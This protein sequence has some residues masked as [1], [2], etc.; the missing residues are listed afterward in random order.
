MGFGGVGRE[1]QRCLGRDPSPQ[2]ALRGWIKIEEIEQIVGAG[3]VTIGKNETGI[4]RGRVIK[5]SNRLQERDLGI[6]RVGVA[7]D[8]FLRLQIKVVGREVFGRAFLDERFLLRGNRR[9]QLRH[10]GLRDFAL[11]CEDIRQVAVVSLRPNLPIRSRIDQVR[12]D[13]QA[14]FG[15]L[16]RSLEQIGDAELLADFLPVTG[17]VVLVLPD[18]GAP[19]DF[20]VGDFRQVG[21][22]LVL[23]AV[24]E[25]RIILFR[26][27][28]FERQNRDA[29]FRNLVVRQA[30]IAPRMPEP[31][32]ADGEHGYRR[33]D[34]GERP[35][36]TWRCN[37]QA[38]DIRS[39]LNAG[40]CDVEGP[41]KNECERKAGRDQDNKDLLRPRW[42]VKD[43]Q[44]RAADLH[45][46][47]SNH[48]IGKGH[49]IDP[50]L[51]EFAKKT[52]HVPGSYTSE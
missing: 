15:A 7:V 37:V 40:T 23:H 16:H 44:N 25:E 34:A 51:F 26:A 35:D 48:A 52:A 49:P 2:S 13:P 22:D 42:R 9:L 50:P 10:D 41:G 28:V 20:Q 39:A 21:E 38:A 8:Q 46:T 5:Q 6:R 30:G 43:R 4:A 31:V 27:Q 1:T 33:P 3:G 32:G 29:L 36:L 18:T 45:Q 17:L 24:G 19:D 47:G 11:N 14:M 12:D